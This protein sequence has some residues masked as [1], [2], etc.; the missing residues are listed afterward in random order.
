MV[1]FF[2]DDAL[3]G[4]FGKALVTCDPWREYHLELGV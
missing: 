3:K 1:C 2:G 4:N